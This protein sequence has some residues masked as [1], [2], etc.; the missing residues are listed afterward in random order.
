MAESR[1]AQV[2]HLGVAGP[3]R[4]ENWRTT[5]GQGA[6]VGHVSKTTEGSEKHS[7]LTETGLETEPPAAATHTR[8]FL[9]KAEVFSAHHHHTPSLIQ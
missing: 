8:A 7:D 5:D 4:R 2:T 6:G 9:R 3:S 1:R